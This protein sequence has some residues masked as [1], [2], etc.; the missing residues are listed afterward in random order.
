MVVGAGLCTGNIGWGGVGWD[1]GKIA[2]KTCPLSADPFP[3]EAQKTQREHSGSR[4]QGAW[5][6]GA[7]SH[8]CTGWYETAAQHKET[9]S[10][11]GF[12][13]GRSID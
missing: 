6:R 3:E 10:S 7:R 2:S 9:G 11:G 4:D 13:W 8:D 1:D 5:L 12:D